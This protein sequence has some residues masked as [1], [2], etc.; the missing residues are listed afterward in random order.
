[1][2]TSL[3]FRILVVL[4]KPKVRWV[5]VA[6]FSSSQ[7]HLTEPTIHPAKLKI[8]LLLKLWYNLRIYLKTGEKNR[9]LRVFPDVCFEYAML[10]LYSNAPVLLN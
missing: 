1:M 10:K 3:A 5:L 8:L 4:V 2:V 6:L 9:D 7:P